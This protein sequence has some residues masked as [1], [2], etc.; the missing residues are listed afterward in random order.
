MQ[1]DVTGH[2]HGA[3][4]ALLLGPSHKHLSPAQ[5]PVQN[6]DMPEWELN[7]VSLLFNVSNTDWQSPCPLQQNILTGKVVEW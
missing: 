1:Q 5:N 2:N 6:W 3:E 4:R 7:W